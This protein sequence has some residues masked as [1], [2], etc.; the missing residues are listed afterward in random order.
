MRYFLALALI[1]SLLACENE[2]VSFNYRI[3]G[4]MRATLLV[5]SKS[6][7]RLPFLLKPGS[8]MDSI[9]VVNGKEQLWVPLKQKGDSLFI[10]LT[11]YPSEIK[12]RWKGN[13]LEGYWYNY[14]K[15]PDYRIPFE[16]TPVDPEL[17]KSKDYG[18]D[19]AER[20]EVWFE[21]EEDKWPAI[22][23]LGQEQNQVFG[24]FRTETGDYRYLDGQL[25]KDGQLT[26]ACF[27][28]A[29]AFLFKAEL[30]NSGQL[31]NGVF[32]SGNHYQ[33]QWQ[34]TPN[35]SFQLTDPDSLSALLPDFSA[36]DFEIRLPN[37]RTLSYGDSL[38]QNQATLIQILGTWCPNCRDETEYLKTV[39]ERYANRG[40]R[41]LAF[42]FEATRDTD[43][44]EK[45]ISDYREQMEVPYPMF[46]AG[47]ANKKKATEVFPMLDRFLSYPTLIYLDREMNVRKIHTGFNGP[48]TS[49]Y[50]SFVNQSDQLIEQLLIE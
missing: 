11:P 29:H 2:P 4:P 23:E 8:Q 19:L 26:L 34:G 13:S 31:A 3:E 39:N 27:D 38:L 43:L 42:S 14:N 7:E 10:T 49:E 32:Y 48:A 12:A 46:H 21:D 16:A 37:G 47:F 30:N 9:A 18:F 45:R 1:M 36:A 33:A 20:Y 50:T 41:I 22:A 44:A 5:D 6:G 24:T 15:G 35:A 25:H 40:L 28:G 17:T